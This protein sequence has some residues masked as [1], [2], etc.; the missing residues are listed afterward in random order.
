VSQVACHTLHV[1][2]H[3]SHVT[4]HTSHVTRHTSHVA[5]HTSHVT[6]R[7][8][9]AAARLMV[10]MGAA[11]RAAAVPR[12]HRRRPLQE[13]AAAAVPPGQLVQCDTPVHAC[14]ALC[15]TCVMQASVR[16]LQPA[17][18]PPFSDVDLHGWFQFHTSCYVLVT[19]LPALDFEPQTPNQSQFKR[20]FYHR[21]R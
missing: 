5:R 1:T 21:K 2:R 18:A 6:R 15:V 16:S 9:H 8:S 12:A 7:T 4:R 19:P 17:A 10:T 3:T 20:R 11:A 13:E 14:A